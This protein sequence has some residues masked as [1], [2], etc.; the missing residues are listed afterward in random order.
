[1]NQASRRSRLHMRLAFK[2]LN[3]SFLKNLPA[4]EKRITI[5]TVLTCTRIVTVPLIVMAM[6]LGHWGIAFGL[7]LYA[8]LTDTVDGT[9]A[10][11]R[12]EQTILGACLDP[13]ADKLL[14]LSVFT[15]LACISTPLFV[16][17]GWFVFLV[18]LKEVMQLAGALILYSIKGHIEVQPTI[19][20]KL[21]MLVQLSFIAWLFACYFFH[22]MPIKTYYTMLGVVLVLVF[23]AFVQYAQIGLRYLRRI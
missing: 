11:L 23:A 20:G 18:L 16:I 6:S 17:P 13:I 12:H 21:T 1:M 5:S 19:L 8:S 2:R 14:V 4:H 15:T 9:L 22:W 10:R 7:F 3:F